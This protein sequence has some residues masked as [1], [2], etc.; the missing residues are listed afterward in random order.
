MENIHYILHSARQQYQVKERVA[1]RDG[2]GRGEDRRGVG[3][4]GRGSYKQN[5]FFFFLGTCVDE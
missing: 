1:A 3:H 5:F 2:E 4:E